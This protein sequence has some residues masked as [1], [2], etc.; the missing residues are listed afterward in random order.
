MTLWQKFKQEFVERFFWYD[1][2]LGI[3]ALFGSPVLLYLT[4]AYFQYAIQCFFTVLSLFTFLYGLHA[5]FS[6]PITA[7]LAEQRLI[8]KRKATR[9]DA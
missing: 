3:V 8:A 1:V 4:W 6:N 9:T 7:E 2:L 5:V